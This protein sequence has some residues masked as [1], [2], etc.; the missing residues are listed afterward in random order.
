MSNN[1]TTIKFEIPAEMLEDTPRLCEVIKDRVDKLKSV[2]PEYGIAVVMFE[3]SEY[4]RDALNQVTVLV[5][6]FKNE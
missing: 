5:N 6:L 4:Q 1:G 3:Q 2:L